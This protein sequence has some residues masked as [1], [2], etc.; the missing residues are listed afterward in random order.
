MPAFAVDACTHR[1]AKGLFTPAADAGFRVGGK[2]F[3][4][5]VPVPTPF[6]TVYS[7]NITPDPGNRHR[8]LE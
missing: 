5:A 2:D 8:P 3:A 4:G 6:G 7:S 1:A